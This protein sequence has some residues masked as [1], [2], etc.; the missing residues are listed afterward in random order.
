MKSSPNTLC[1]FPCRERALAERASSGREPMQAH[2][3]EPAGAARPKKMAR[4]TRRQAGPVLVEV[5]SSS[6]DAK[7]SGAAL[8]SHTIRLL[9]HWPWAE[10]L[11]QTRTSART[12][13]SAVAKLSCPCAQARP[14]TLPGSAWWAWHARRRCWRPSLLRACASML[15]RASLRASS[16]YAWGLDMC[17]LTDRAGYSHY[18]I[19]S[20]GAVSYTKARCKADALVPCLA[21]ITHLAQYSRGCRHTRSNHRQPQV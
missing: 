3:L 21:M 14:W 9:R 13:I 2:G 1:G 17:T 20:F 5:L 12:G 16:C 8:L 6:P 15:Q 18:T 19:C 10:G 4:R 7:P 11:A